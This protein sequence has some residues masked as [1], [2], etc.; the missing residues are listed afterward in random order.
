[1]TP[2]QEKIIFN[3]VLNHNDGFQF[4]LIL[5]DKLGAFERGCNFQNRDLDMFNRGR[6]EAGLWLA[7]KIQ[8]Y[9]LE[10]YTEIIKERKQDLWK[11]NNKQ[12]N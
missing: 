12:Q 3:N 10:K 8:E 9:C 1:M 5:L 7:D 2:E 11:M 6:R 4:V